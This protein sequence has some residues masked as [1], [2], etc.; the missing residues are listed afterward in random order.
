MCAL[1]ESFYNLYALTACAQQ[2]LEGST[3]PRPRMGS[4]THHVHDDGQL[5]RNGLGS[6][7]NHAKDTCGRGVGD[8]VLPTGPGCPPAATGR[9]HADRSGSSRSRRPTTR[10]TAS[11]CWG[12]PGGRRG[13]SPA[14]TPRTSLQAGHRC[15]RLRHEWP[16]GRGSSRDRSRVQ[17]GERR[18]L[19]PQVSWCSLLA[20]MYRKRRRARVNWETVFASAEPLGRREHADGYP[21]SPA[22]DTAAP[23]T[24]SRAASPRRVQSGPRRRV[25]VD[26]PPRPGNPQEAT[27]LPDPGLPGTHITPRCI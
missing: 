17:A 11:A 25:S 14:G 15:G 27:L 3:Q 22:G 18:P 9:P 8:C 19:P 6:Q 5:I 10:C 20:R 12:R 1:Q 13:P 21:T 24:S 7:L 4:Y 26:T 16:P 23:V 2:S